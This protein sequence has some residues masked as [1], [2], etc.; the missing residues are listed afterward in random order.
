MRHLAVIAALVVSVSAH[1]QQPLRQSGNVTPGHMTCWTTTNVVQDC[2]TPSTPFPNT[3]GMVTG[4]QVGSAINSMKGGNYNQFYTG[5]TPDGTAHIG[6]QKFGTGAPTSHMQMEID[7]V[8]YPFPTF[9]VPII[10]GNWFFAINFGVKADGVTSD[11]TAMSNAVNACALAGGILWLPPGKILL[12]G[13]A[14]INLRDC[15]LIGS[16]VMIGIQGDAGSSGTTFLL[17]S[18]TTKPFNIGS[19]WGIS[20]VQFYWPN[21]TTGTTSYPPLFSAATE[22]TQTGGWYV[23]HSTFVNCYDCFAVAGGPFEITD[24]YIYAMRD[25]FRVGNIGDSFRLNTIHFTPGPWYAITGNAAIAVVGNAAGSNA[26]F[27]AQAGGNNTVNLSA[28][29][30]GAFGW[31]YG[32]NIDDGVTVA[33]ADVSFA[34]DTVG[35]VIETNSTGVWAGFS[36]VPLTGF[37][38]CQ[39]LLNGGTVG[40]SAPCFHTNSASTLYFSGFN[41]LA[42]GS[43]LVAS[44]TS[45]TMKNVSGSVGGANDGT[46]YYFV[47][48]TSNPGGTTL[49]VQNSSAGGITSDTHVHGIKT[50]AALDSLVAQNN[51][52]GFLNDAINAQSAPVTIITG[53][54][55]SGTTGSESIVHTSLAS[56]GNGVIYA[57]NVWDKPPTSL[58]SS[59]GSGATIHGAF[60]GFIMVGTGVTTAC[61]LTLPW[62]PV[63]GGGGNCTFSAATT[64]I[65][66]S[67]SGAPPAWSIGSDADMQGTQIFFNCPGQ[68]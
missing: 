3:L 5:V 62:S 8:V 13:A 20:G 17:T 16:G 53:N 36:N 46:D 39:T 54:T 58:V 67:P 37:A 44:G 66:G 12:T 11:D 4:N 52:F 34:L 19:S 22:T 28:Q 50:D 63:G 21:Q 33:E 7:G 18:T 43:L 60:A 32:I 25:A 1:A 65:T 51:A 31:R 38:I 45:T 64:H 57:N 42:R 30:I 10:N 2:G 24:S 41:F 29:N 40:G 9:P 49:V 14:T 23:D 61:T 56:G 35:T 59:C 26:M 6:V 15:H 47:H 48:E 68:Q 55:S 27:H